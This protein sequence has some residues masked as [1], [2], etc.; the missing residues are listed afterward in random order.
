MSV[1]VSRLDR[2]AQQARPNG[3]VHI[4]KRKTP[5]SFTRCR[6]LPGRGASSYCHLPQARTQNQRHRTCPFLPTRWCLVHVRCLAQRGRNRRRRRRR[7]CRPLGVRTRRPHLTSPQSLLHCARPR[8]RNRCRRCHHRR[9]PR[10]C[11]HPLPLRVRRPCSYATCVATVHH[12]RNIAQGAQRRPQAHAAQCIVERITAQSVRRLD[13]RAARYKGI[14]P[15]W[16]SRS[17]L[18]ARYQ[19]T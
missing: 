17:H 7:A 14:K 6:C 16:H 18:T 1:A 15:E 8:A 13:A 3:Y 4:C 9:R 2:Q 11:A 10:H 12:P 5:Q 19:L